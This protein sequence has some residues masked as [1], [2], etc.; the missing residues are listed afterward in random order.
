MKGIRR[1]SAV[2]LAASSPAPLPA[3][4][5][6]LF[7]GDSCCCRVTLTRGGPQVGFRGHEPCAPQVGDDISGE[8]VYG[9]QVLKGVL[10]PQNVQSH[11]F[12]AR[13]SPVLAT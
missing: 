10:H 12:A 1:L 9:F 4:A 2:S 3:Y 6:S 13:P 5:L 11:R 8:R 7:L